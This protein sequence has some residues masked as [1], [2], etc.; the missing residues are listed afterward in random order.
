VR[1]YGKLLVGENRW[2]ANR[3]GLDQGLIDFGRGGIVPYNELLEEMLALGCVENMD[4]ARKIIA[5]GTSAHLQVRVHEQ[6]KA[7]GADE[8]EA[9]RAVVDALIIETMPG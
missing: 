2:P 1:V 5:R 6:A 8:R 3:Y 7:D 4:H 9:L